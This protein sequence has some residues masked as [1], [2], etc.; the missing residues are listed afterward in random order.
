MRIKK[1]LVPTDFSSA[2]NNA[3]LYAAG[4]AQ[5]YRAQIDLFHA[6]TIP[7][8]TARGKPVLTNPQVARANRQVA[9]EELE[10]TKKI[11]SRQNL[12][13]V[14]STAIPINW[15]MELAEVIHNQKADLI[16]MGTTGASGLK[17]IFMGSNA[18]R[19]IQ[20]SPVPVL[21]VPEHAEFRAY[22]KIGLAY[23]GLQIKEFRKLSI[24]NS[25]KN[26]LNASIQVFQI[27]GNKRS[28]SSHLS[29]LINFLSDAK[30]DYIYESE[31]KSAILKC[32]KR[33]HFD[34]LVMVPR[35]HGFFHNLVNGSITKRIAYKISIPLLAIPE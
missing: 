4:I 14:N 33:N 8:L 26:T 25:F 7:V 35:H 20:N 12:L 31:I 15:Q 22:L 13:S 24:I 5:H 6:Y 17:K 18:A 28:P 9:E 34:M 23:D 32:I 21:A 30:G 1:I 10:K 19:V 3:L 16:V 27:V 2:A 11:V 29:R